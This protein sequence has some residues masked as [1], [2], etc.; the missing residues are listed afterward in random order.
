LE[1][2][3]MLGFASP[4]SIALN[5]R[6]LTPDISARSACE[7]FNCLRLLA[8]CFPRFDMFDSPIV[9]KYAIYCLFW[10]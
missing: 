2:T 4:F 1:S 7:M 3:S 10:C 8:I 6:R 9:V 5:V